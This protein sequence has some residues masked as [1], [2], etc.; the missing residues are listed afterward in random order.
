MY[1]ARITIIRRRRSHSVVA[2]LDTGFTGG[3][4]I[5]RSTADSLGATLVRPVRYPRAVDGSVI[6][7]SATILRVRLDDA[8]VTAETPAF[9]PSVDPEVA[10]IGAF[11]LAQVRAKIVVGDVSYEPAKLSTPNPSGGIDLGDWV[12]PT[13]R[14]VTPWW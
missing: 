3:L 11:F 5:D 13:G 2:L 1:T 12:V 8:G 7:G 14:A 9:C 10:L 6:R 4:W